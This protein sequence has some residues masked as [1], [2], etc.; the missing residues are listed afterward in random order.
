MDAALS[1]LIDQVQTARA[2]GGALDIRGGGTKAFY[3][4][5]PKGEPL[6]V[7]PLAGIS[8][9]EPSELVVT[10]RAG[11]PLA[12]LEAALTEK[13]QCLPFE[14]PRFAAGGNYRTGWQD[15]LAQC[16]RGK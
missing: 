2:A 16:R 4:G 7:S 10:V 8:N 11:T 6:D 1:R 5:P 9:Y 3:G 13:D 12:E 15:G 14:P